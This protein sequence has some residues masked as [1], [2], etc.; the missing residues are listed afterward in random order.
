MN[1]QEL[2]ET[3]AST[4]KISKAK[5]RRILK[6]I[7]GCLHATLNQKGRIHVA[8]MGTF[9]VVQRGEMRRFIPSVGEH[10]ILP[11]SKAIR[12]KASSKL[13]LD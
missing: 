9:R 2:V 4:Q 1:Q 12:F 7:N 3:I 8:G 11:P 5:A 10:R 6:V 13:S